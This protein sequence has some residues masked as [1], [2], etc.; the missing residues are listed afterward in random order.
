MD[1]KQA[2]LDQRFRDK[3]PDNLRPDIQKFLHNPGCGCNHPIYRK[4]VREVPSLLMEYFP[5]KEPANP[6]EEIKRLAANNWQV[7]N[8]SIGELESRL[9][10]MPA[11]RK[12]V[13]IARY[14]DQV[15]VIVNHL[16]D[17]Y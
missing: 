13:E 10:K 2:L 7:I 16:D 4:I 6:D 17:L 3:L 8:C 11:G 1:V 9:K 12:Q 5:N 15:T 14:H